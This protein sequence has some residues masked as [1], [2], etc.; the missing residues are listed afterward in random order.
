M[1]IG[2]IDGKGGGG[3]LFAPGEADPCSGCSRY[4]VNLSWKEENAR[5]PLDAFATWMAETGL[6]WLKKSSSER[7]R[8]M[9]TLG[10]KQSCPIAALRDSMVAHDDVGF[11]VRACRYFVPTA[12]LKK[13]LYFCEASDRVHDPTMG[14]SIQRVIFYAMDEREAEEA[15]RVI[16]GEFLTRHTSI[17]RSYLEEMKE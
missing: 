15:V 1:I 2:T 8:A 3:E 9:C 12:S 13:Y 4:R 11:L 5:I 16:R 6:V 14:D 10:P 17:G 7:T